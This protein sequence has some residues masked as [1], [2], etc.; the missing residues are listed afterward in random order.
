MGREINRLTGKQAGRPTDGRKDRQTLLIDKQTDRQTSNNQTDRQTDRKKE[1]LYLQTDRQV[2]TY[3]RKKYQYC[4]N[5]ISYY[6]IKVNL[7][8]RLFHVS[9]KKY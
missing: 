4:E 1:R 9:M 6:S 2:N 5:S 3:K 8:K 7:L